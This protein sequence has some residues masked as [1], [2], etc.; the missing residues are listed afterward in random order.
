MAGEVLHQRSMHGVSQRFLQ[1]GELGRDI[2][3]RLPEDPLREPHIL[4]A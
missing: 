1:T 3:R 2:A 4:R